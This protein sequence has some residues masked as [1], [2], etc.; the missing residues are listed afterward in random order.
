MTG[1]IV[2][3]LVVLFILGVHYIYSK[4]KLVARLFVE[5]KSE[6]ILKVGK[7]FCDL[8]KGDIPE[9]L[10]SKIVETVSNKLYK[11]YL[12]FWWMYPESRKRYSR[13]DTAD[14]EHPFIYYEITLILE[15]ESPYKIRSY[16]K[17][18]FK[19]TDKELDSYLQH[20]HDYMN[21]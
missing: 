10:F 9:E 6:F 15:K 3:S 12:Y 20:K 4:R 7:H 17:V 21:K 14:I 1:F 8:S 19:M 11:Q 2:S 16:S 18:L 13:L 5:N